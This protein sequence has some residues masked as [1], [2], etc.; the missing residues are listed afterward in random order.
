MKQLHGYV[1]TDEVLRKWRER[2][3]PGY[4]IL[5][6]QN[7]PDFLACRVFTPHTSQTFSLDDK[8]SFATWGVSKE[9]N[10]YTIINND[11]FLKL[12]KHQK[13]QIIKEQWELGRGLVFSEE[14]M[15]SLLK[16][17]NENTFQIFEESSYVD[18]D[19]NVKVY[20][21]QRFLL[22]LLPLE[23][24][25][26]FLLNYASLWSD[27]RAV[28]AGLYEV[29]RHRLQIEY[30]FLAPF[31]DTFST[32]NGPN[33]LA[34]TAAG[35]SRDP[36]IIEEWMHP[37]RFFNLLEQHQYFQ[38]HCDHLKDRDVLVWKNEQEQ[39][40]HA[41]FLLNS[42]YCFNKHGQTM[43]NPWQVLPVEQVMK[44]WNQDGYRMD[45]YRNI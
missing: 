11:D 3:V 5:F 27:D 34:A 22:R 36:N 41:A 38:H 42:R 24:Q 4:D 6:F 45:I 43:F 1:L 30:D 10:Y 9:A 20:M 19:K 31:L 25:T 28:Y 12:A 40:V 2:L 29:H 32:K 13:K 44:S 33:C 16:T 37:D 18:D 14:E 8:T 17:R 23:I 21:I 7:Q 26:H 15:A 35:F 39:A